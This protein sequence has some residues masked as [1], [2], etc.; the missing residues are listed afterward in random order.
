MQQLFD[1]CESSARP[2]MP[3]LIL[4]GASAS[5]RMAWPDMQDHVKQTCSAD[6]NCQLKYISVP[7]S[8]QP[9]VTSNYSLWGHWAHVENPLAVRAEIERFIWL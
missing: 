3:H 6:M 7:D 1:G 8:P 5:G 4:Y 2:P 9:P